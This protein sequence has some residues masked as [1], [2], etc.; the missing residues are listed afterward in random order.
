MGPQKP[1]TR[2]LRYWT[3]NREFYGSSLCLLHICH[4]CV[5]VYYYGTSNSK[6]SECLWLFCL[7]MRPFPS[8]LV[9]LSRFNMGNVPTLF[10]TW[11][12]MY[13]WYPW[14]TCSFLK[15]KEEEWI[16]GRGDLWKGN[17]EERRERKLCSCYNIWEKKKERNLMGIWL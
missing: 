9:A 17:L 5:A 14:D 3:N 11:N 8:Y 12:A 1:Q 6:I 4:G 7:L 16:W 10:A 13:D 2:V 15:G